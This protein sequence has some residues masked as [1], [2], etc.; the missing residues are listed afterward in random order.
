[1]RPGGTGTGRAAAL[2]HQTA[3][4]PIVAPQDNAAGGHHRRSRRALLRPAGPVGDQPSWYAVS[5]QDRMSIPPSNDTPLR[6]SAP[7]PSPSTRPATPAVYRTTRLAGQAH[8]TG[9]RHL[10]R[11]TPRTRSS[12][13]TGSRSGRDHVDGAPF[14]VGGRLRAG[15]S[16]SRWPTKWNSVR[17]WWAPPPTRH[18]SGF[19]RVRGKSSRSSGGCG[20]SYP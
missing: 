8:R 2:R 9:G 11:A 10:P 17:A 13:G 20:G 7:R 1:M 16:W 4:P 12:H 14:G 18:R 19:Q 6:G 15:T 5:A 3:A